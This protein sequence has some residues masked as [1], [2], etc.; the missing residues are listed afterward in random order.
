MP[1]ENGVLNSR[2]SVLSTE[3]RFAQGAILLEGESRLL[4]RGLSAYFIGIIKPAA[5]PKI[6]EHVLGRDLRT[7][8]SV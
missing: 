2:N 4:H 7:A 1:S 5:L 6:L 3:S 8:L